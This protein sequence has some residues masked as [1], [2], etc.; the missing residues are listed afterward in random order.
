MEFKKFLNSRVNSSN[1]VDYD[2]LVSV[3]NKPER[4]CGL[5]RLSNAKSKLIQNLTQSKEIKF[6]DFM[7]DLVTKYFEIKGYNNLNKNLGPDENGN[8]LNVDQIFIIGD[9]L[10][11]VEQK[12]RDDHDSTKKRGQFENFIKNL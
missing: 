7:E 8:F 4:Y 5:F 3:I 1:D 11:F 10:Y 12:V 2:L 9:N 6:G